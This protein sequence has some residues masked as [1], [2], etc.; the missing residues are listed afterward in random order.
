[1]PTADTNPAA[2]LVATDNVT[3]AALIKRQL[4]EEFTKVVLSTDADAA[5]KDFE[6]Y[7]PDVLV[8]A[9]DNLEKAERYYLGLYR[10]CPTVQQHIHRTVILCNKEEVKRVY[11]LCKKN[12]FDDYV[13]FWP[14]TYDMSRLAM[15]IHHALRELATLKDDG[16]SVAEFA[17]QAR[18]LVELEGLLE[19]RLAEGSQHLAGA[20]RAMAQA[21]QDIGAALDGFSRRLI[22]GALPNAVTVNDADAL[23]QEIGRL[24]REEVANLFSTAAAAALPAKNWADGLDAAYAPQRESTRALAAMAERVKPTVL[25]ADDDEFQRK[26]VARILAAANYHVLLAASGFETLSLLR[27]TRPDLILMDV[28]MPDLNGIETTRRL[29]AVPQFVGIPVI[30]ITGNS[31]KSV[32]A[33]CLKAGAVGFLV[34]PVERDT[35]LAKVAQALRGAH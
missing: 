15:A 18:R 6:R 16:P 14:M 23:Q 32:V 33:G 13:L 12:Y 34:K 27:K 28:M 21:E 1:M 24:K 10:L 11:E 2:I 9:F 30:M 4:E 20:G 3:D 8:L 26:I 31:E 25:V 7:R 5:A 35:L 19:Q 22:D 29:K 17:A